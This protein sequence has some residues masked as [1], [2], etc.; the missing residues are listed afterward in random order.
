[1]TKSSLALAFPGSC[2]RLVMI[3]QMLSHLLLFCLSS[4][5]FY[6]FRPMWKFPTVDYAIYFFYVSVK[7]I[8]IA[9]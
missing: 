9:T 4:G 6:C 3:N 5:D 1:M 8:H 7:F 2:G